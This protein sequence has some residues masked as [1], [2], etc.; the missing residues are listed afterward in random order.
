M[1]NRRTS[2]ETSAPAVA[3]WPCLPNPSVTFSDVWL[4]VVDSEPCIGEAVQVLAKTFFGSERVE[5]FPDKSAALEK[6]SQ[7]DHAPPLIITDFRNSAD[8]MNGAQFIRRARQCATLTPR[9]IL[10]SALIHD[11]DQFVRAGGDPHGLP[12]AIVPKPD[13]IELAQAIAGILAAN[14]ETE[15]CNQSAG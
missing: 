11:S 8:G 7:L 3:A 2:S 6:L 15:S 12:D 5:V 9:F 1:L 14:R 4:W 13:I 10:F